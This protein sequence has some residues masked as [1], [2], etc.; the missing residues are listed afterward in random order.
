MFIERSLCAG[1]CA[2]CFVKLTRLISTK[3]QLE[4]IPFHFIEEETEAP[5]VIYFP[6]SHS[7]NF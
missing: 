3:C 7:W 4:N 6:N 5:K 1:G 2:R